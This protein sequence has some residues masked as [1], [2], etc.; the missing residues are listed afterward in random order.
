MTY[1]TKNTVR[2]FQDIFTITQLSQYE[3]QLRVIG[4]MMK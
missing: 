3:S 2:N 1:T 4:T